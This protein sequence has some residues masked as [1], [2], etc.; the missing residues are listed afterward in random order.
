MSDEYRPADQMIR[1]QGGAS[2]LQV[3][4]RLSWASREHP[5][6]SIDTELLRL[7][8][9]IAVFRAR[10]WY[11]DKEL[12]REVTGSGHG[13][14]TPRGFPAGFIE[15]AETVAIGRALAALRYGTNDA[16][17]EGGKL[18]DSPVQ[19]TGQPQPTNPSPGLREQVRQSR[20]PAP[21]P[22]PRQ[23]GAL[24]EPPELAAAFGEAGNDRFSR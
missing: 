2:Y 20:T 12:G 6:L 15:K 4:D 9:E 8:G 11:W 7:D 17:E 18:A 3:R 21:N 5:D 22:S 14:E 19:R 23:A 13:S 24:T 10:V 1:I 16:L